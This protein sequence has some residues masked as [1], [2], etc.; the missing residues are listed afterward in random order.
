MELYKTIKQAVSLLTS[1]PVSV[2]T[3]TMN[4]YLTATGARPASLPFDVEG[5]DV[6]MENYK[7]NKLAQKAINNI[8]NI[9]VKIGPYYDVGDVI[10]VINKFKLRELKG[11]LDRL[12]ELS[13]NPNRSSDPRVHILIGDILGYICPSD[14][15]TLFAMRVV[16]DYTFMIDGNKYM[17]VWCPR[18]RAGIINERATTLLKNMNTVLK[19][20]GKRATLKVIKE[21]I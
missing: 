7:R 18:E 21:T 8:P 3:A 12:E 4:I 5:I 10:L 19:P 13:K 11:K 16:D 2:E 20:L 6:M 15:K 17:G 1:D 14:M 9:V